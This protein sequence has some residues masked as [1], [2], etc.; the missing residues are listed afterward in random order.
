MKVVKVNVEK[1]A[2]EDGTIFDKRADC[3]EYEEKL[4]DLDEKERDAEKYVGKF[5]CTRGYV[6]EDGGLSYEMDIMKVMFVDGLERS[7]MKYPWCSAMPAIILTGTM[8]RSNDIMPIKT[9]V[10]LND[11]ENMLDAGE[12]YLFSNADEVEPK[13]K[14]WYD[15]ML[16]KNMNVLC[17]EA[18]SWE[19]NK[20]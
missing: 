14:D 11:V 9:T 20:R 7:V 3:V 2:A 6:S 10:S 19:Y 1:F 16:K 12:V 15:R 5:I 18:I 13:L 4:I 8:I 17:E